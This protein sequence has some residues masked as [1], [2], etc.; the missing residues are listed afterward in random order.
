LLPQ[1]AVTL[2]PKKQPAQIQPTQLSQPPAMAV[3]LL[4]IWLASVTFKRIKGDYTPDAL[5]SAWH[6]Y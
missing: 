3:P 2:F 4:T 6:I 1:L 5:Y